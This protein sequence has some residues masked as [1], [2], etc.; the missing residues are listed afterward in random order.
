ML[1]IRFVIRRIGGTFD[2]RSRVLKISINGFDGGSYTILLLECQYG[3]VYTCRV[4]AYFTN[5]FP[6]KFGTINLLLVSCCKDQRLGQGIDSQ[7]ADSCA[8]T[9]SLDTIPPEELIPEE[10]SNDGWDASWMSNESMRHGGILQRT[11]Q[12]CTSSTCSAVMTGCIDALEEPIMWHRRY[13]IDL[14]R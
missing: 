13:W 12:T 9:E 4:S 7:L 1:R 8:N 14:W 6:K 11:S 2:E 10:R 5:V 3:M